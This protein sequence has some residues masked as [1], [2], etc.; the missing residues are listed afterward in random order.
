LAGEPA[1]ERALRWHVMLWDPWF[2]VWG[3]ALAVAGM[4]VRRRLSK[5]AVEP[6]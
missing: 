2:F 4:S 1:D 3:L 5:P 6:R